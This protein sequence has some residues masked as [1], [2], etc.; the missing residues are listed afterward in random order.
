[1]VG[2]GEKE[3]YVREE[4]R[5]EEKKIFFCWFSFLFLSA[6]AEDDNSMWKG[7]HN[8]LSTGRSCS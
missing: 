3:Q 7:R 5:K 6:H 2:T 1:M 8:K 4:Q